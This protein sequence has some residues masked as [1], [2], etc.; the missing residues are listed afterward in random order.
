[1]RTVPMSGLQLI[2][3]KHDNPALWRLRWSLPPLRHLP[4]SGRGIK[5]VR[6]IVPLGLVAAVLAAPAGA[7]TAASLHD[8]FNP[9]QAYAYTA[10]IAG[11]GERWPRSE[12]RRVGKECRSRWSP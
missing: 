12:E 5:K 2:G 3:F 4:A 10:R 9:Q 7:A 6:M 11:F 1:M 8:G